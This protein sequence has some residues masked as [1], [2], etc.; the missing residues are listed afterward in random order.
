MSARFF[1]FL[2]L[3]LIPIYAALYSIFPYQFY[4]TTVAYEAALRYDC[5]RITEGLREAILAQFREVNGR[6]VI[7]APDRSVDL[8]SIDVFQTRVEREK[9]MFSVVYL[10]KRTEWVDDRE[11]LITRGDSVEVLVGSALGDREQPDGR[12]QFRVFCK[13]EARREPPPVEFRDLFPWQRGFDSPTFFGSGGDEEYGFLVMPKDLQRQVTEY[14]A[15]NRG[16]PSG[17]TG[18]FLRMLY[19]SAVTITTVGY[20]DIVPITPLART[21]VAS[22]AIL[23]VVVAGLFLNA[24]AREL[25]NERKTP[26]L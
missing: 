5:D 15:A 19:F 16:F 2:Y 1:G 22:E 23:G 21:L 11:R 3:L 20:G 6:R 24:L 14:V 10:I 12:R 4:H 18:S 26:K 25:I 9:L 8:D 13:P 7:G 17:T